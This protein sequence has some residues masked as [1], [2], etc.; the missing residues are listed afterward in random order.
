[1]WVF[2]DEFDGVLLVWVWFVFH[3]SPHRRTWNSLN[4]LCIVMS[5]QS[6]PT[7][8]SSPGAAGIV[9]SQ[10]PSQFLIATSVSSCPWGGV[11]AQIV[12]GG[13][14]WNSSMV[15]RVV[16]WLLAIGVFL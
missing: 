6:P 14:V 11:N 16:G 3:S 2:A 5:A 12:Y 8:G 7:H 10:R 15:F 1:M 9:V 13:A 4:A